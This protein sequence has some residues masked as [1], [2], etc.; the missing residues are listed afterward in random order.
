M[1]EGVAVQD[2]P[3]KMTNKGGRQCNQPDDC[4]SRAESLEWWINVRNSPRR[5]RR[6]RNSGRSTRKQPYT[7]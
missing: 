7:G 5:E 1:E 2:I 4:V 6:E 3:R